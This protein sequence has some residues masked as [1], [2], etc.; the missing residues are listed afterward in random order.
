VPPPAIT[1]L[2]IGLI[3]DEN[4]TTFSANT[5]LMFILLALIPTVIGHSLYNWLL[6]F[7]E[8]HKVA[9][10]I[11]GEPIGATILAIFFFNQI[12]GWGTIIGGILILSGICIV[13]MKRKKSEVAI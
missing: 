9:I 6:K 8:A 1:I 11:L 5:W 10:T 7:V 13:L 3:Q 4:L 2:L 12:P